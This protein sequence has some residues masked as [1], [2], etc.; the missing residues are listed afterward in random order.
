MG[1]F[2]VTWFHFKAEQ[3]IKTQSEK[4]QV[5][6]MHNPRSVTMGAW[7]KGEMQWILSFLFPKRSEKTWGFFWN[8]K[9]LVHL[10][11][12]KIMRGD[13]SH[14]HSEYFSPVVFPRFLWISHLDHH[15]QHDDQAWTQNMQISPKA[16]ERSFLLMMSRVNCSKLWDHTALFRA[17]T[18]TWEI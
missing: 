18:P 5:F 9:W 13:T 4:P 3:N 16:I 7:S 1:K 2:D 6:W 14:N 10:K 8:M 17:N 11:N 15:D 12:N